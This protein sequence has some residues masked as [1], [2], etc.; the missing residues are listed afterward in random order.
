MRNFYTIKNVFVVLCLLTTTNYLSSQIST[1]PYIEDFEGAANGPTGCG[2]TYDMSPIMWQNEAT[3]DVDWTCDENGTSSF[4]TGPSVDHT[5]GIGTGHYMYAETSCNGTGYS[6][7]SFIANSPVFD[8]SSITGSPSIS[9]WYHMFGPTIGSMSL[10][11]SMDGGTTWMND[12][13]VPA[14]TDNQDLWQER[15]VSS[16]ALIGQSN[17]QFRIRYVSGVSFTGDAAFDDFQVCI[18]SGYDLTINSISPD[19]AFC[20]DSGEVTFAGEVGAPAICTGDYPGGVATFDL[21]VNGAIV[22]TEMFD[23][24]PITAGTSVPFVFSTPVTLPIGPVNDIGISVSEAGDFNMENDTLYSTLLLQP[25]IATFPYI[26]DFEAGQGGWVFDGSNNSSWEFGLPDG[27]TIDTAASGVNAWATNLDGSYSNNEEGAVE[28][29][30]FDFTSLCGPK[31]EMDVWWNSEF[32]WDGA[33]LQSSIDGQTTWQNIGAFQDTVNWYN[34]NTISAAPGGSQVGWTGRQATNNGSGGYVTAEHLLDGLSGQSNVFLRVNFGSD[35]SVVDDGFAFDNISIIDTLPYVFAALD[36][37]CL[38]AGVQSGEGGATP[39]GGVYSGPGVTDDGNG[40]T[41]SFDP[42]VAGVGV[43]IINYT[44]DGCNAP[45]DEV[46]VFPAATAMFAAIVDMPCNN[47]AA[48]TGLTGGSPTGGIYSGTGVTDDGNGMTFSFD[49]SAGIVG[50]NT[51]TYTYTNSNGCSVDVTSDLTVLEAPVISFT[52]LADLCLNDGVQTGQGGATPSGG[53]YSGL[54]V[55]D[56]GNG[57]TYSF[58][59]VIAG[60]GTTTISYTVTNASG[61]TEVGT[62]DVTVF[63]VPVAM[64]TALP[65]LCENIGNQTGLGGGSPTGG[66]YSG[67]GVSDDGN[68]MT[69]TFEPSVA[70]VGTHTITYTVGLASC[71]DTASDDV[72][73]FA[74]TPTFF[75][76]LADQ[77][78]DAGVQTGLGG[79]MP[80]GGIYSGIGV[81]DDGNGMTYSFDPLAAGVGVYTLTYTFTNANGCGETA[82]DDVEVFALPVV[83]AGMYGPVCEDASTITLLGNPLPGTTETGSWVGTGVTDESTADGTAV[84]DPAGLNGTYSLT[85]TFTDANGCVNFASTSV[86]VNE[87]PI[88][89]PTSNEPCAGQEMLM[90]SS[91]LTNGTAPFT[92]VWT[93]PAGQMETDANPIITSD[94]TQ[95]GIWT[96]DIEDVNGCTTSGTVDVVVNPVPVLTVSSCQCEFDPNIG[97]IGSQVTYSITDGTGPYTVTTTFGILEDESPASGRENQLY[98]GADGGSYTIN[99]TDANGCTAEYSSACGDCYF[100]E[101]IQLTDPCA[102]NNDQTSNGAEDGTFGETIEVLGPAGLNVIVGAGSE[103]LDVPEGTQFTESIPGVYQLRFNH[104]DL[105]GY[106]ILLEGRN[107]A[108]VTFPLLDSNNNQLTIGNACQY[109]VIT[110]PVLSQ[111]DFCNN[112]EPLVFTGNEV[113]EINGFDGNVSVFLGGYST[114]T[115][116]S[117]FDPT[118]YP[119]GTYTLT[120][121]FTGDFVDN[122]GGT[123]ANPAFPGCQTSV[124]IHVGVGGG[125]SMSCN[126]N[127]NM[128]VNANC[129]LDFS[130][131]TLMESDAIPNVFTAEFSMANGTLIDE[132]ELGEFAGQSVT[133]SIIDMCTGNSCWGTIN[134]EDKEDPVIDCEICPVVD[135]MSAADYDPDCV[136]A[137]YEQPILQLRYDDGLRD[138]LVQEDY[139]DFADDA[140]SDNCDNWN[141]NQ[142]SFYD[143]YENL[144]DCIGT[145]LTR[146]WSVGFTRSDGTQGSVS[147]T[148]QYFF[149][150]ID[151]STA[152]T[153]DLDPDF[154]FPII[155]PIEDTLVLPPLMTT[156]LIQMNW[157]LTWLLNSMK[158]MLGLTLTTTKMV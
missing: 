136:L 152:R 132:S 141:E 54:G 117:Q 126:D 50:A 17:V 98:L 9:F 124:N 73:V 21:Y 58:D 47:D 122:V 110:E 70:G 111:L 55:T 103:G 139:E 106:T 53:T 154:G 138:D 5:T 156:T 29:P 1:F 134:I 79:G 22:S 77:C 14:W 18:P 83:D 23:P 112:G 94:L 121:L 155:E 36:D 81:T 42:T 30:C 52:A 137:C 43:H 92:Y 158:V 148:R 6:N 143:Q 99:V 153:Y 39:T 157:M 101:E 4:G 40:M 69:Y 35:G 146:T 113:S 105:I 56:D 107:D 12:F 68:G 119:N 66:I 2:P 78:I 75:T 37:L 91:N 82:D 128:T 32:S 38:D 10:D 64:F 151:L 13:F 51:I 84:F 28:S 93:G 34:D 62:D 144:G 123:Q 26:E 8:F 89:A 145:R 71:F 24:G 133:Y 25:I 88:V 45:Q 97:N 44:I 19:G 57:M 63:D 20:S 115:Q 27:T 11:V 7:M 65:D 87:V 74:E 100:N 80:T 109:P 129:E 31:I 76:A 48:L 140:M 85:Y 130:W 90:L 16:P 41:Y 147:C 3:A 67:P 61:C 125:G 46:E 33:N 60:V 118:D 72:E 149:Q 104:V 135:G 116:I 96:L 95:N 108:G 15:S 120:F 127:I 131:S 49:P 142:V 59:P 86:T 102:C 150:P 114:G